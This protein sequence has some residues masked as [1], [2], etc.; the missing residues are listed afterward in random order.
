[1][2]IKDVHKEVLPCGPG[3]AGK[4]DIAF[5]LASNKVE[6]LSRP[7]DTQTLDTEYVTSLGLESYSI[8][9]FPVINC[10]TGRQSCGS[11]WCQLSHTSPGFSLTVCLSFFV[12]PEVLL[13]IYI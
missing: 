3:E 2:R 10:V 5:P 12:I 11:W 13:Y 4:P 7:V 8:G 9:C 6:L 1:M